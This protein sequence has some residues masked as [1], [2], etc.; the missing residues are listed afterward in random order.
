MLELWRV[1][2]ELISEILGLES[3]AI[4]KACGEG[5]QKVLLNYYPKCPQPELALGLKRHTDPGVIT[6]ALQDT[7][8][9]LQVTKDDGSNWVTVEPIHS[10]FVVFLGGIM[11]VTHFVLHAY[12][13]SMCCWY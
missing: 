9:G 11:H 12:A 13:L 1:L 10:A 6:I 4:Q 5:E 7:V 3:E 8:G 2:V